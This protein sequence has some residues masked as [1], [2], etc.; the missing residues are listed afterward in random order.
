MQCEPS[1]RVSMFIVRPKLYTNTSN[2][3]ICIQCNEAWRKFRNYL[4]LWAIKPCKLQ[5][6]TQNHIFSVAS[7]PPSRQKQTSF[8]PPLFA[9]VV[10]CFLSFFFFFCWSKRKGAVLRFLSVSRGFNLQMLCRA[11]GVGGF[12]STLVAG[13][14]RRRVFQSEKWNELN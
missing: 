1:H 12:S 2:V 14:V 9:T 6:N 3:V 5:W 10:S 4:A 11:E 13:R 8:P 7:F